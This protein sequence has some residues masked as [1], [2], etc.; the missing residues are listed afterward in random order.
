[1]VQIVSR[2]NYYHT[3]FRQYLQ[4]EKSLAKNSIEA[5]ED[6]LIKL[7]SIFFYMST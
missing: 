7:Q 4:L 1:M 2:W 5:Y 3:R 6:D